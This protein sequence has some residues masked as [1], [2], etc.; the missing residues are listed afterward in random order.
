V[1]ARQ[2]AKQAAKTAK[3]TVKKAS[4]QVKKA[5]NSGGGKISWVSTAG[6]LR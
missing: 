2:T 1:V 6:R 4:T 3:S 5:A